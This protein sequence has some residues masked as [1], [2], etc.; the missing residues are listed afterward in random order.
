MRIWAKKNKPKT[1]P[2]KPNFKGSELIRIGSIL[3]FV[4]LFFYPLFGYAGVIWLYFN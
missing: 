1:N 3:L 2:I 4:Y